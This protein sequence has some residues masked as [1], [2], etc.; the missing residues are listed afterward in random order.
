MGGVQSVARNEVSLE[1]S[2]AL[3]YITNF[4]QTNSQTVSQTSTRGNTYTL[5]TDPGSDVRIKGSLI[6]KQTID[7]TNQVTG[8]MKTSISSDVQI[9]IS[10]L[11]KEAVDQAAEAKAGA[12]ATSSTRTTNVSRTKS[13]IDVAVTDQFTQTN[14]QSVAQG[15]VDTNSGK[16]ILRGKLTV[17]ESF[18]NDQSIF[19]KLIANAVMDSIMSRVNRYMSE[20]NID[21]NVTQKAKSDSKGLLSFLSNPWFI[22]GSIVSCVVILVVVVVFFMTS[23]K[24]E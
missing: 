1:V 4:I 18:I 20:N 12:F 6:N 15:V 23:K 14:I 21:L 24:K 11:L 9:R 19:G 22:T 13:A 10:N 16:L 17:D 3:T 5:E 8:T 2:Q 7:A